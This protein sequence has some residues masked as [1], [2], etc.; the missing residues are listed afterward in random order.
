LQLLLD[1]LFAE[2]VFCALEE[3]IFFFCSISPQNKIGKGFSADK[4]SV[5][6]PFLLLH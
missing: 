2:A 6:P 1:F 5:Q 3:D 4:A